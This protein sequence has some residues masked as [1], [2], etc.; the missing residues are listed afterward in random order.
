MRRAEGW[1]GLERASINSVQ[2]RLRVMRPIK[3]VNTVFPNNI[4][5]IEIFVVMSV[6]I[7]DSHARR[8]ERGGSG[9]LEEQFCLYPIDEQN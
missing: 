1:L 3:Q 4:G 7:R 8:A 9:I 2:H 5:C 6:T